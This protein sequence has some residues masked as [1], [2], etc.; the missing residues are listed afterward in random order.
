[1]KRL[2]F[3]SHDTYGLGNIR[4]MLAV[5][6]SLVEKNPDISALIL[7]GSPMLQAFRM[8]ERIDYVKL[9]CLT[10]NDHGHYASKFLELPYERLLSLRADLIL[11]TVTNYEPDLI[12]VDKKP[13]GVQNELA[14]ALDVLRRKA[15][16]PKLV[17]LLRE[18]LDDPDSTKTIW[19]RNGYHDVIRELYDSVLVVGTQN[20]FDT[21]AEYEFPES[22]RERLEYCGYIEKPKV[23]RPAGEVREEL[24]LTGEALIL[25]TAG[26]GKDGFNLFDVALRSFSTPSYPKNSHLLLCLGPE[27]GEEHRCLLKRTVRQTPGVTTIDYTDDMM[28]YMNAASVVVSMSGYNTVSELLTLEKHA[29]LVPRTVPV[30]EQW[31]RATRLE[32]LDRFSVIHPD[33]LTERVLSAVLRRSLGNTSN[34]NLDTPA[35]SMD[36][37]AHINKHIN[38]LLGDRLRTGWSQVLLDQAVVETGEFAQIGPIRLRSASSTDRL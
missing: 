33:Q 17:L 24:D 32:K 30:L 37:L 26:G 31:I 34:A 18:I 38:R 27:M 29:V 7:S 5:V 20:V 15:N 36:G 12:L 23:F 2:L 28:S 11:N 10:R 1:M 35:V 19:G 8:S 22:T 3:Y 14:P 25:V 4:R 16:R 6:E 13:L 21:A 9:P